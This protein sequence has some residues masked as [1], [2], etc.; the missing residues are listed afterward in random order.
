M[1]LAKAFEPADIERRWYPAWEQSGHFDAGLDKS[2]TDAFCI[3]LPPPNVTGTLHMGHGFNQTI[4]DSL[5]RYYRMRGHNTLWQP[6]TDH[7]GIATQIVVER[8]LDAQGISRHDLGREKFL[9]K[10]WEWKEYSGGT[11]TR[12]MRRLGTSPDWKRERFTMDAGLSKT[13]TETFVRL[14]NEGLIYRGKRLVNWDPKLGTAV[15]DLEVVSEEEEG[16]LWHIRYPLADGSGSLT[17]A[18][19]R[20]ETMLGDTAVMVH[21]EDPRYK[22]LIGKTVKLPLCDREIP[23]IADAYVDLEFG[24]GCVKVTPAHDFNDYAVGQR[25]QLPMISILTLDARINDHAPAKYRGLDRFDARKAV[26]ADL[27]ALGVLEK[28]DKHKLKV[29]RGDRTGVVIEPMLT[30]QWFVAMSKAAVGPNSDGKSITQKALEVVASGEIKFYPENWVN[31]YNQWLNNI[32]DWCISRQLWWGHQIPAWYGDNGRCYVAHDESEARALAAKDGYTGA[33]TRDP[34]VLDTW[35]SSALWPFSTLDWTPE[36]PQKS[37]DAL[38]LY[39]P[40]TVLVTGFDIIFFWVA[41]MVMMTKHITGKIPFKHVYVHGL[42]RDAEGQ[43][44]SKSKGNVLDPIDLIDGIGIEDLVKKRTTGLMNPKDAPKIEKRTRK[45]FPNGIASFGTDALRFTFASLASPGRDI[46]FDLARCEGYRNFC[47][48][49]WN[50]TRFVLMN[51][52]G[53]DCG[54]NEHA[55]SSC[56]GDILD[57]S[58]ADRWIVSHLQ[59]A[60]AEVAEHFTDYRF[61]L[62]AQ[63]IYRLVWD[64]FCDWYL[65]LA[66]VQIQAGNPAQQR[67]TRR[68]LIRV[69]ETILRLAHPVIPFIT[70]ELWQTVAPIAGRKT[71][72]SIM[73]AAYPQ[74]QPERIDSASE[75]KVAE[76]KALAGACR[77]LRGEMNLSPAQKVPLLIA[78][79]TA[80][81]AAFGPYLAALAKLSEVALV[82]ELPSDTTAPVAVVGETRLMLKIEVDLAAEKERLG[83]E[84]ARLEGEI[85]KCQAKLG[86]ESFVGR[87]PAN[88]VEQEKKRLADFV[89]T[90]DKLK[91]QLDQLN[92][93]KDKQ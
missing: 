77:N 1:E 67:A 50:A 12:Q 52:E 38:D 81:L 15:S 53:Q 55:P 83:K 9:E 78:G 37:N 71:T 69:L 57:F 87:A 82:D 86:N 93:R 35:Y 90:V 33:L 80:E 74:A 65:E 13:V 43:K 10:V 40:S 47:N 21:P 36:W 66:K 16:F 59:R 42:I 27:E 32:Q 29:P 70:E 11:I 89:V 61:D 92:S 20:P 17:V 46:K 60:E 73:V 39:L 30:D 3:L 72:D 58:F 23:I 19:T 26:V 6:G 88:V 28:T 54:L 63:T 75:A 64:E 2:K 5:T 68:T 41:R 76:L 62:L 49:L 34:D 14:H 25:H 7:A 91:P 8:Q 18:T 45:E 22:H 31:T 48:K 79:K 51:C 24:T 56:S 84:I 44:M 85:V 4:M